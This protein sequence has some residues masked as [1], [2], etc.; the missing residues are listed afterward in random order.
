MEMNN[1][2]YLQQANFRLYIL[3]AY[4]GGVEVS[5]KQAA[6]KMAG[7]IEALEK[8]GIRQR[9]GKAVNG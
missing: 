1:K 5:A 9:K 7:L 2:N 6:G 3:S 4:V 8:A